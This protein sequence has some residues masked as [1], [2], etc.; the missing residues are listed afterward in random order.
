[1]KKLKLLICSSLLVLSFSLSFGQ[2]WAWGGAG[3]G[4][5]KANDFGSPVATDKH[6]NVY[7]TGSFYNMITFG[8][9]TL[10]D[11]L[12]AAY[13]VK[14]NSAGSLVWAIHPVD[15]TY[16]HCFGASVATD[17]SGNVYIAGTFFGTVHFGAFTLRTLQYGPS[18]GDA[19][20]AKYDSNG[21][22]LWAKEGITLTNSCYA[23][24]YSMALDDSGNPFVA[25]LF[26]DTVSFG[27][28]TLKAKHTYKDY[29]IVKYDANGNVLWAQQSD[30]STSTNG[31]TNNA[32]GIATDHSG[33]AYLTGSFIGIIM[34]N[35]DTLINDS[36]SFYGSLLVKYSPAGNV[37]WAKQSVGA[38]KKDEV[39][40]MSV[41]TDITGNSYIT[42]WFNDT[43]KFGTV[44]KYSTTRYNTFLAKYDANGNALWVNAATPGW[45]GTSVASD[46]INHIYLAGFNTVPGFPS[47]AFNNDTLSSNPLNS[48][49]IFI[50]KFDT[51]GKPLCGSLLNGID[52]VT[53]IAVDSSGKYAYAGSKFF[54]D[55]VF[56]GADTLIAN[57]GGT[58][59]FTGRWTPCIENTDGNN[60]LRAKSEELRVYPNPF[61]N[62]TTL[63]VNSTGQHYL[64]LDDVTGRKLKQ[65]E[66]TGNTYTL[67][68]E[69]LA[70]G[71][72]F[73]RVFNGENNL[74]GTTK[75]V[76]Q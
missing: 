25:G 37:L 45:S 6:G 17:K 40:A 61:N 47:I 7:A 33:N 21:T 44:T 43:V 57:S 24:A 20:I 23:N 39:E 15:S 36:T 28:Y 26:N 9:D 72:Y 38:S 58:D 4:S 54:N 13:F 3:Y 60:E 5:I 41:T 53:C 12:D 22:A 51:S 55:S 63:L 71:M 64:E 73:I 18:N 19:F 48:F 76:V 65:V 68:A 49:A 67:S 16:S 56:C 35:T 59:V 31:Y 75:I 69:G 29:F 2:N 46:A 11:T 52:N 27:A 32:L 10:K 50:M 1:M 74:I 8:A 62:S 34:F 14:Y 66:F 30:H 42:G 70:K